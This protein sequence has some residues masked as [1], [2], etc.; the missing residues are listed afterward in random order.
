MAIFQDNLGVWRKSVD[1]ISIDLDGKDRQEAIAQVN[2]CFECFAKTYPDATNLRVSYEQAE[3]SEHYYN[4]I[5]GDVPA[6]K[7]EI[8]EHLKNLK[9][10][11]KVRE[12]N[13]RKQFEALK[14]KFGG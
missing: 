9:Y 8:A 3:Y 13:E 2:Y 11:E 7:K 12:D 4:S 1:G 10:W 6:T 5:R 14:K